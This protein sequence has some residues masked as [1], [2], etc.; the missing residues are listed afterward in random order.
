MGSTENALDAT[1]RFA[2]CA[3]RFRDNYNRR[4][5]MLF[6]CKVTAHKDIAVDH[7]HQPVVIPDTPGINIRREALRLLP[8]IGNPSDT[9]GLVEV[10]MDEVWRKVCRSLSFEP[11]DL[12]ASVYCRRSESV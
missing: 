2:Y 4:P 6:Y 3:F 11:V 9:P 1:A 5:D 8:K 7:H 10:S 12:F